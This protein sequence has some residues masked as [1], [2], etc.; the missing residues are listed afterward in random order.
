[1][2]ERKYNKGYI[3]E[4]AKILLA[5]G[6]V[7]YKGLSVLSY[8]NYSNYVDALQKLKKEG[9]T[10]H[11]SSDHT[12]IAKITSDKDKLQKLLAY[13]PQ[14][15]SDTC[16][17]YA[18]MRSRRVFKNGEKTRI[19]RAIKT[20]ET[21]MY[22]EG[23]NIPCMPDEKPKIKEGLSISPAYYGYEEVM[24]ARRGG[25]YDTGDST[26]VEGSRMSGVLLS[27]GGNYSVYHLREWKKLMKAP[28][29]TEYIACLCIDQTLK[30]Y[31]PHK[32]KCDRAI[33]L[34]GNKAAYPS[35]LVNSLT[36]LNVYN[37][38]YKALYVLPYSKDGQKLL[39]LMLEKNWKQ[40]MIDNYLTSYDTSISQT[41]PY[42]AKSEDERVC[43]FTEPDM[44]KL[45][46]AI[47]EAGKHK[48]TVVICYP[49][50]KEIVEECIKDKVGDF[51]IRIVQMPTEKEKAHTEI[52]DIHL[53]SVKTTTTPDGFYI[54]KHGIRILADKANMHGK[55]ATLPI[56]RTYT[57]YL[58]DTDNPLNCTG[59]QLQKIMQLKGE[60]Y[61]RAHHR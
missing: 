37:T 21:L 44:M 14:A 55:N 15:Y 57:V 33:A 26:P 4:L 46:Y 38:E 2:S 10:L 1:M 45:S 41:S 25:S 58:E 59:Y 23:C 29:K 52:S 32:V 28:K 11:F 27:D 61:K 49:F 19:D 56:G 30:E 34:V 43:M 53:R 6:V 13:F 12:R 16:E 8:E 40:S 7:S 24:H 3:G 42:H 5:H 9:M 51:E 22:M 20:S 35:F 17:E 60:E 48:K 18:I 39:K 47:T 54:Y 50:Q 31:S 36:S